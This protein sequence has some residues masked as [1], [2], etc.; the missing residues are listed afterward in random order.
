MLLG[1]TGTD[2]AGKGSVVDYLTE[3][4]GFTHYSARSFILSRINEQ[5]LP[6]TRNQMRLTA[7]EL[8]AE[9]GNDFLV[10]QALKQQAADG[11]A[12]AVVESIRALAEANTLKAKGGVLLAV[13]ADQMLRFTRVQERRSESDQVT[14]DE[15]VAHEALE[16]DD[17]DP[18]GMQKAKVM[19]I[20]DY[21]IENNGTLEELR[22]KVDTFLASV[23]YGN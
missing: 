12:D 1:I 19:A 20:A 13:D 4:Y 16:K 23:Q 3:R 9:Y 11:V 14:F 10:Q 22:A 5:G 21:T 8:R 17:P 7:N 2:G 18:N 6:S 15:F